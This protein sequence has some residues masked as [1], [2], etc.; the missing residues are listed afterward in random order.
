ML[1]S[2][3]CDYSNVYILVKSTRLI[4][5]NTGDN[6]N[7]RDKEVVFTNCAPHTDCVSE[8]NNTVIDNAKDMDVVVP[9]KIIQKH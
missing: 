8:I 3:L 6:P 2:S 5:A 1:K 7:N 9:M 4:K